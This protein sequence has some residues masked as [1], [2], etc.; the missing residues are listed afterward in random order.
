M[1][2]EFEQGLYVGKQD[3]GHFNGKSSKI[4]FGRDY[5]VKMTM[6]NYK[7]NWKV[8]RLVSMITLIST[9]K[10]VPWINSS[11]TSDMFPFPVSRWSRDTQ[12]FYIL[13]VRP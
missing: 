5:F 4:D 7:R 11:N 10:V 12:S 3:N 8:D 6:V 2:Y 13:P 9:R 1:G